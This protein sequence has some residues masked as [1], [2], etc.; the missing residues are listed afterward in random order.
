MCWALKLNGAKNGCSSLSLMLWACL[1]LTMLSPVRGLS[2]EAMMIRLGFGGGGVPLLTKGRSWLTALYYRR[3]HVIL[4]PAKVISV[5]LFCLRVHVWPHAKS[6][7]R[8]CS[9][10]PN[11]YRFFSHFSFFFHVYTPPHKTA[12][13]HAEITSALWVGCAASHSESTR[14]SHPSGSRRRKKSIINNELHTFCIFAV[15]TRLCTL[16]V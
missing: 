8:K 3:T 13:Y 10:C 9:L 5:C 15:L 6:L 12:V 1:F 2:S 11:L 14:S 7:R 4:N 16:T